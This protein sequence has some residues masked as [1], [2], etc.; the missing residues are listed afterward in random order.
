MYGTGR[1]KGDK[2]ETGLKEISELSPLPTQK[3]T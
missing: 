1:V 3:T 2:K